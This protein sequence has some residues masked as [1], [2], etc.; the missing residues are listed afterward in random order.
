MAKNYCC[1]D[2]CFEIPTSQV[3]GLACDRCYSYSYCVCY[4]SIIEKKMK[5]F[6]NKIFKKAKELQELTNTI[7]GIKI[8]NG[9]GY[10]ATNCR[11]LRIDEE[12]EEEKKNLFYM[13]NDSID[14]IPRISLEPNDQTIIVTKTFESKIYVLDF[15]SNK[16]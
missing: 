3:D 2:K 15:Y 6:T 14:Y 4:C 12:N 13:Y 16:K 11:Y 5:I 8:F 10:V 1:D 9:S 7:I